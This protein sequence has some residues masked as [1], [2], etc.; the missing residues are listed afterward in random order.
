VTYLYQHYV[1]ISSHIDDYLASGNTAEMLYPRFCRDGGP[2]RRVRYLDVFQYDTQIEI[3]QQESEALES[4]AFRNH[5]AKTMP[6]NGF[7]FRNRTA[8][9]EDL[10]CRHMMSL[11][12]S[13]LQGLVGM[14]N[15]DLLLHT[16]E[17]FYSITHTG[18]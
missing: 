15:H 8:Q 2:P 14:A 1:F 7:R 18:W 6:Q 12:L 11:G 5:A 17:Q 16:L 3:E 10:F 9:E 4:E 13:H